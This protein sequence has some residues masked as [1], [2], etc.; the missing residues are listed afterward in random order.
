MKIVLDGSKK[1]YILTQDTILEFI[2]E[3][4]DQIIIEIQHANQIEI[5]GTFKQNHYK[6]IFL[7]IN[8]TDCEI[9]ENYQVE[10]G[11]VEIAY[12]HFSTHQTN[13]YST[14]YL[15]NDF[16]AMRIHS[17]SLCKSH[18][19][20]KQLV[21]NQAKVTHGEMTH[22]AVCLKDSAFDLQATG[23][24]IKGAQGA[25]N[26][27]ST[28]CLTFDDLKKANVLPELLIDENDVQASHSMSIGQVN[29]EQMFYL[30]SRG[31]SSNEISKLVTMGYV[32][33]LSRILDDERENEK[34]AL[35]IEERV[36]HLCWM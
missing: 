8:D 33:P 36:N 5:T 10:G 13:Y 27:Q 35:K 29:T 25:E 23:K 18:I 7:N 32:M 6:I 12:G 24:I 22:F 3:T 34:L 17:Y 20:M 28:K 2:S 4:S 16:S 15:A 1:R 19:Q 9:S 26:H 31:L 14:S 30:Q 21:I 11:D